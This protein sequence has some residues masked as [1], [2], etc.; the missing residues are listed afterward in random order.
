MLFFIFIFLYFYLTTAS[1]T[2]ASGTATSGTAT[3]GTGTETMR[4]FT[5]IGSGFGS[6][7][8]ATT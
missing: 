2:T 6:F 8:F 7:G 5:L 1:G 4:L 3:S